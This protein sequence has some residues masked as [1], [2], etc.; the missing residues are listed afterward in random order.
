MY[1][2][3]I[4]LDSLLTIDKATGATSIVGSIG[5][6]ANYAQGLDFDLDNNILYMA[7][8]NYNGVTGQGEMRI[9]DTT[10][11]NTTLL[12]TFPGSAEVDSLA[13][14]A[15]GVPP[16][17]NVPWV[18]EVPTNGVIG[19]D[20]AF[21]VDVVFDTTGLTAGECYTASLGLMHND[22]G[23]DTPYYLPLSLCIVAPVYGV[24]LEPEGSFG[25]GAPGDTIEYTLRITNTGNVVDTFQLAYSNVDPDWVVALPVSSFELVAGQATDVTVLVTIPIGAAHGETDT[26]TLTATSDHDPLV[27]DEVEIST[28]AVVSINHIFLPL[29][30]KN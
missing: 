9:V 2:V 13:V 5:F 15:G 21:D 20:G 14:E 1:G 25:A 26:F 6:T 23:W 24:D 27:F 16:W 22:G 11:G 29:A 10:T 17:N 12:G 19:P 28:T 7:A 3:D 18:T 4:S 8:Y 30:M